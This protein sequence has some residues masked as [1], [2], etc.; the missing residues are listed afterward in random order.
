MGFGK[1]PVSKGIIE[2]FVSVKARF[3]VV[4][5]RVIGTRKSQKGFQFYFLLKGKGGLA[6]HCD[7]KIGNLLIMLLYLL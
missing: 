4:K 2:G 3:D 1:I 5:K 7:H 6:N